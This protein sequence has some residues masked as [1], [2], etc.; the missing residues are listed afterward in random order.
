MNLSQTICK[1]FLSVVCESNEENRSPIFEIKSRV[2]VWRAISESGVVCTI[3]DD[4]FVG[5]EEVDVDWV[6]VGICFSGCRV[7]GLS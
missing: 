5:R 3:E 2:G 7:S 6:V 1:L 4:V